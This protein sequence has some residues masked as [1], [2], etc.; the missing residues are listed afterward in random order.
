MDVP[1]TAMTHMCIPIDSA[2]ALDGTSLIPNCVTGIEDDVSITVGGI[3]VFP[4]PAM[5]IAQI[6]LTERSA[7]LQIFS[8]DGRMIEEHVIRS[9]QLELDIHDYPS[10][11][12]IVQSLV[13]NKTLYF[14]KLI[15]Q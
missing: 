6:R 3:S 13:G 14:N 12:Y 2:W 4:N 11:V 1:V 5:D 15:K 7:V 8:V 9:G 10:G